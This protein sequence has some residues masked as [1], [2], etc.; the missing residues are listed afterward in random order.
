MPGAAFLQQASREE[1]DSMHFGHAFMQ[2]VVAPR[3]DIL[4]VV[5]HGTKAFVHFCW[6]AWLSV[7]LLWIAVQ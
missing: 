1:E 2:L 3:D 5:G 6:S 7:A 4:E